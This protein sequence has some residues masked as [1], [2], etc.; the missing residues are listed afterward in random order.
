MDEQETNPTARPVPP[1]FSPAPEP[2]PLDKLATALAKAQAEIQHSAKDTKNP[3]FGNKYSTL[4]DV[5]DACREP[6][7]KNGLSIV[8]LPSTDTI[9]G[10]AWVRVETMLL[11]ESGQMIG[12]T[13]SMPVDRATAQGVGSAITYARRYSLAA[14]VGV[15][16]GD[17]DDGNAASGNGN[18]K[19]Q[20]REQ[21]GG[22][23]RRGSGDNAG[24][25]SGNPKLDKLK[26]AV[27]LKYQ[28]LGGKGW[29]PWTEVLTAADASPENNFANMAKVNAY[30]KAELAKD[31][32]DGDLDTVPTLKLALDGVREAKRRYEEACI[33]AGTFPDVDTICKQATGK[34]WKESNKYTGK[35]LAEFARELTLATDVVLKELSA[36]AEGQD[37]LP[38]GEEEHDAAQ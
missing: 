31:Q 18:G 35:Q 11:H 38:L 37:E 24:Q 4:A 33:E 2:M 26:A 20:Q 7:S 13:I 36:K 21:S 6:L 10:K 25:K 8:Q 34:K 32:D 14:V 29:K 28:Q 3:H 16:P 27:R 15:A 22:D 23:E 1:P 19:G 12:T 17:D 5:W 30:L 9:D